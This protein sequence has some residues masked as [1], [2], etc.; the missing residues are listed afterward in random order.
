MVGVKSEEELRQHRQ[1]KHQ[2]QGSP[3]AGGKVRG[4]GGELTSSLGSTPCLS[5]VGLAAKSQRGRRLRAE[6]AS[7]TASAHGAIKLC[8]ME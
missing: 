7:T 6:I 5:T 3:Q 4:A 2:V 8:P 1:Q